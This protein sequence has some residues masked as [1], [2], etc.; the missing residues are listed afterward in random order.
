MSILRKLRRIE[1]AAD[2]ALLS[3]I[4]VVALLMPLL[5]ERVKLPRLM[6]MLGRGKCSG[7]GDERTYQK[8]I[9]F[10]QYV[11]SLNAPMVRNTCLIRSLVLFHFLRKAGTDVCLHIGVGKESGR[12]VA[13]SWLAR[14]DGSPVIDRASVDRYHVIYSSGVERKR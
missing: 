7:H 11:L 9:L 14:D 10:T 1:T 13:H 8:I 2:A 3:R 5:A 6:A 12:I 4:L